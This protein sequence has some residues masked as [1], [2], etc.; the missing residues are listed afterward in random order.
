MKKSNKEDS[1]G[2]KDY[3][4]LSSGVFQC[5]GCHDEVQVGIFMSISL[6][7]TAYTGV[8]V[9]QKV[10]NGSLKRSWFFRA[11]QHMHTVYWHSLALP[12][13][14]SLQKLPKPWCP[15][16]TL[17]RSRQNSSLTSLASK[18]FNIA[19]GWNMVCLGFSPMDTFNYKKFRFFSS[20]TSTS[21]E[22]FHENKTL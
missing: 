6:E 12:H 7:T 14:P 9:M 2:D 4:I 5:L 18:L 22:N 15:T 20:K 13:T 19:G 11:Q 1:K 3:S 10:W 17:L 8:S 21:N 16:D